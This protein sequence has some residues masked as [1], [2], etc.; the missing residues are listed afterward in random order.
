MHTTISNNKRNARRN[1]L[2]PEQQSNQLAFEKK[3]IKDQASKIAEQSK[4]IDEFIKQQ[5]D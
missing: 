5:N 4:R 3:K 2:N 1:Q